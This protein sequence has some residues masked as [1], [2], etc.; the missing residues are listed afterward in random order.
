[1]ELAKDNDNSGCCPASKP[2]T[3]RFPANNVSTFPHDQAHL[4]RLAS[5]YADLHTVDKNLTAK[6]REQDLRKLQNE[7]SL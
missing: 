1:M 4:D 2:P 7:Q 3:N 5:Q 6:L